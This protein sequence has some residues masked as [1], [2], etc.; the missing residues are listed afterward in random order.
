MPGSC[1]SPASTEC[2]LP[3]GGETDATV[4]PT[5]TE[6]TKE[7]LTVTK[8]GK[9]Q[10]SVKGK[11]SGIS[12]SYTCSTQVAYFYDGTSVVLTAAVQSGK[13]SEFVE[14]TGACSG[15]ETTCTVPMTGVKSVGAKF[16]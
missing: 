16:E 2:V 8:S 10:G 11:P 5:F 15:S 7:V 4:E 14:W 3:A 12:C 9:G 13:G 1:E 6:K